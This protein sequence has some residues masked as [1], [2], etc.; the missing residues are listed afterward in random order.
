MPN[1]P[2][3]D[4]IAVID[5]SP[6]VDGGESGRKLVAW[7]LRETLER[8]GFFIITGHGVPQSL[9]DRTFAEARRFHARPI[10]EKQKVL[11]NEHNNG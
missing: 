3:L 8:I 10:A 11:M 4:Q 7:Q 9:V 2:A 1:A 6:L 5:I